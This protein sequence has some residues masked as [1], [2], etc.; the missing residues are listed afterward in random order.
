MLRWTFIQPEQLTQ[1]LLTEFRGVGLPEY[2]RIVAGTGAG[3][4]Y[5][6]TDIR[7]LMNS[8][9]FIPVGH[10]S[11][12]DTVQELLDR[13]CRRLQFL[14]RKIIEDLRSGDKIFVYKFTERRLTDDEILPVFREIRRLGDGW[15]LYV[16]TEEGGKPN[17]TVEVV[18]PGFMVGYIDHFNCTPDDESLPIAYGSWL[19]LCRRAYELRLQYASHNDRERL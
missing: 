14:S 18:K 9:T 2:T 6:T 19:A 12:D 16:T 10:E 8:H 11:S 17:G 3:A 7:Y 5:S 1:A 4:D 15:L 13:L